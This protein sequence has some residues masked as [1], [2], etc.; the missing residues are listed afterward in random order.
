MASSSFPQWQIIERIL[1][2]ACFEILGRGQYRAKLLDCYH[3][4]CKA[5]VEVYFINVF[6]ILVSPLQR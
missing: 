1:C 6:F 4:M 2:K 5:C 3:T